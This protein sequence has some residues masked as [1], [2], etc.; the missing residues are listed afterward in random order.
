MSSWLVYGQQIGKSNPENQ[1]TNL[2]ISNLSRD[3]GGLGENNGSGDKYKDI[4]SNSI[5]FKSQNWEA[6]VDDDIQ[7]HRKHKNKEYF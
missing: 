2:S 3:A 7:I 4:N 5:W 1:E 6:R